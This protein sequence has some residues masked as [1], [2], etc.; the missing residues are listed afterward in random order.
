MADLPHFTTLTANDA[1]L[2]CSVSQRIR[3][4]FERRKTFRRIV[5]FAYI[6]LYSAYLIWRFTVINE[7]ALMLSVTYFVAE[8]LGFILGLL[9][10]HF[11]WSY[12]H[13]TPQTPPNGLSV[14]IFVP[15]YREPTAIIRRTL[16]AA[17]AIDYP[18]NT[19][20]LDDGKRPE[21][22]ALADELGITYVSRETNTHAKAGNLNF[23]LQHSQADF[24]MVF[25]AD[26]IAMPH[27]LDVTLGFFNDP[28]VSLVQAPQ[29]YYNID[30][31][32]YINAKRSGTLWHDQ[33]FFYDIAQ[34]CRDTING[35]T[36]VGTAS[37]YRRSALD[38]ING[39]PTTTVTEDV[40]TSLKLHKH[41]YVI[42]NINEPIA[43][44]IAASDLGEYYK[45]RH[46]WAHGNLH[47]LVAENILFCKGLTFRQRL[48]YMTIGLI[49]LEGWQQLLLFLIPIICMLTGLQPFE[50]TLF[51]IVI[52]LLFP[53]INYAL[54]QELG[55]GYSRYWTN[56]LFSMARWPINI[57]ASLGLFA[58]RIKWRSS[59]KIIK[60]S[61]NWALMTPQLSILVLSAIALSVGI[62]RLMEDF[63]VGPPYHAF[64]YYLGFSEKS[65][66]DIHS[67]MP[68]GY[69]AELVIIAGF[70]LLYNAMRVLCF[71]SKAISNARNSH[72]F[73]RFNVPIPVVTSGA[74][75]CP[76]LI[77]TISEEWL[78]L[79]LYSTELTVKT[80]DVIA[81][82]AVLP[83]GSLEFSF[84]VE[85]L[86][87]DKTTTL[88][89]SIIWPSIA[90][91]DQ[92]ANCLYSVE[93]HREFLHRKG[94]FLTLSEILITCLTLKNPFPKTHQTWQAITYKPTQKQLCYGI[95]GTNPDTKAMSLITFT[96]LE[97]ASSFPISFQ[98]RRM[99]TEHAASFS[100]TVNK[101]EAISSLNQKGLD[102]AHITRYHITV[103]E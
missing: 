34:P 85:T 92:L 91:H 73:H 26:H 1:A 45:T 97:N 88:T 49:Y 56:E 13:R 9:I 103:N 25:D 53:F 57:W 76:G 11:S 27:A 94:N 58:T 59:S 36:C 98:G 19:F 44:G 89:G 71:V 21:I 77:E 42:V 40:H 87:T 100:F 72:E 4:A 15:T 46:R 90:Q 64:M 14:D 30:A 67:P 38:D 16:M 99:E 8:C 5:A 101:R 29:H 35:A 83:S 75:S 50:I 24:L 82:N 32:Q 62:T 78:S 37:L 79:K 39:F 23:G 28:K 2:H 22:K 3:D 60:G 93:W 95:V 68:E 63:Q 102:G 54:L 84:M 81:L 48:A 70:W 6:S 43:Y 47:A 80:G 69:T 12:N 10:I 41:G 17:K 20:V 66:F 33:S 86:S 7:H 51:N 96:N 65:D 55:C 31:F 52:V 61:V 74:V 18:H